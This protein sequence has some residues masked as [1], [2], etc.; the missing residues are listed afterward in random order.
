MTLSEKIRKAKRKLR[1]LEERM[2]RECQCYQTRGDVDD[3]PHHKL[4]GGER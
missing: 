3:C 2:Q 4:G 1:E